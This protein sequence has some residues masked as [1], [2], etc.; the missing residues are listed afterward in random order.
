MFRR[1]KPYDIILEAVHR[2]AD[3]RVL[4]ARGYERIL[5]QLYSDRRIFRRETLLRAL[6]SGRRIAVGQRKPYWGNTFDIQDEVQ[7]V[8]RG[9]QAW[10][11]LR[12]HNEA[13]NE[14]DGMPML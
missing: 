7:L 6:Q 1:T 8:R 2:G 13:R 3:G 9:G 11:V 4:W 5:G 10:M 14:L 12:S